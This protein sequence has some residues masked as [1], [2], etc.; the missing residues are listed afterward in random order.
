[1]AFDRDYTR[2]SG[3][4]WTKIQQE[5]KHQLLAKSTWYYGRQGESMYEKKGGGEE[6]NGGKY[7]QDTS[8][9]NQKTFAMF[10]T[11]CTVQCTSK[12]ATKNETG[13]FPLSQKVR[14]KKG[15]NKKKNDTPFT[16][17]HSILY[18]AGAVGIETGC[19]P[20]SHEL[21]EKKGWKQKEEWHT[22]HR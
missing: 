7:K 4:V 16:E 19:L 18:E 5:I 15:E 12:G 6:I 20:L 10:E 11:H 1:M 13:W 3:Q 17:I 2:Q 9:F 14:N 21:R 22:F 8:T